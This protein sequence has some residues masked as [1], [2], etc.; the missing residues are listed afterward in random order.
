LRLQPV[1]CY[2]VYRVQAGKDP[3]GY[4]GLFVLLDELEKL[5]LDESWAF[6]FRWLLLGPYGLNV[7]NEVAHGFV[8]DISPTYAALTLR[9]VSVLVTVAGPPIPHSLLSDADDVGREDVATRDRAT[10]LGLLGSPLASAGWIDRPSGWVARQL[11]RAWWWVQL[12]R[13]RS[14]LRRSRRS[15]GGPA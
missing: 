10:I 4:P 13:T 11:D 1:A 7:R 12:T 15:G 9:A 14:R 3:G 6:F 2:G 8:F 5:A